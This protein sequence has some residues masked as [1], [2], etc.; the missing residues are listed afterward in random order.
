MT[1]IKPTHF[2]VVETTFDVNL[3]TEAGFYVKFNT[4]RASAKQ[5]DNLKK[6]LVKK[7]EEV[8]EYVDLRIDGWAYYK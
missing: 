6:V 5:L 4:M 8:H 1:N 7:R 2:E 3:H